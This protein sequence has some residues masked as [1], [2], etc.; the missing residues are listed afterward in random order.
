MLHFDHCLEV[1][2]KLTKDNC[3]TQIVN[4]YE[5]IVNHYRD[6]RAQT[7]NQE[8]ESGHVTQEEIFTIKNQSVVS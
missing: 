2:Y 6:I 3:C 1:L 8:E 7:K 4:K 5:V